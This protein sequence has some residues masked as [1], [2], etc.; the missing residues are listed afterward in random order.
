LPELPLT[1]EVRHNLYLASKESLNNIVKHAAASEV[2]IRLQFNGSVF[3]FSIEDNGRGFDPARQ[4][5]RGNGLPNMRKRLEDAGGQCELES[6]PGK[7]T[8]VKFSITLAHNSSHGL[9]GRMVSA[10][11]HRFDINN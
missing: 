11:A 10:Q 7:G 9:T 8:R 4:P 1:A 5:V 6:A 2:W 3:T